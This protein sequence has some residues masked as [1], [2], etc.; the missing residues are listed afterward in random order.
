MPLRDHFS[1]PCDKK[2]SWEGF[3]ATW[4]VK[5]VEH[6]LRILPPGYSAE[7]RA[8]LGRSYEIDVAANEHDD[9]P[10]EPRSAPGNGEAATAV[11][12]PPKPT[13]S[14]ETDL[15]NQYEYGVRVYNHELGMT[16]VAAIELV[17]PGNKDRPSHRRDFVTKCLALL[18]QGVCVSIIDLVK[19]RDFNLYAEM[20]ERLGQA[21]PALGPRP[22]PLYAATC[23]TREATEAEGAT[24]FRS[25]GFAEGW[26]RVLAIGQR[27]PALPVWL[28]ADQS[29]SLDLEVSYEEACRV[30]KLS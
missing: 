17:S 28:S 26:G 16:M 23:R 1:P 7:P 9:S 14:F 11:Q 27:L 12:A 3:H 13:V 15:P 8:R 19:N 4:P 30:F 25:I 10:S 20:L 2:V 18:Q 29:I 6:L 5:M 24:P 22:G 21:D